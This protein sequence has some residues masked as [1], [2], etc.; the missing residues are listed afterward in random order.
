[1]EREDVAVTATPAATEA[2]ARLRARRGAVIFYQSGGCCDGSLPICLEEGE[3]LLGEGD[4]LLGH[5]AGCPFYIDRRQ[6]AAWGAPQ[7]V[8]DVADGEP[9][10][11][12]LGADAD[13]HF[14][15]KSVTGS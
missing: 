14:V 5:V 6:L 12:S 7:L 15:T 1:M 10:G 4:V 13:K 2:V 9:E 8:L 11:F 3:L